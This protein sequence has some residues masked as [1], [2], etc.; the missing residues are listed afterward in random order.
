[1]LELSLT[2]PLWELA[3]VPASQMETGLRGYGVATSPPSSAMIWSN[4]A[5]QLRDRG[6]EAMQSRAQTPTLAA[7]SAQPPLNSSVP[8][9]AASPPTI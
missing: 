5:S 8:S 2:I 1:M 7:S 4:V 6:R 9:W 3:V